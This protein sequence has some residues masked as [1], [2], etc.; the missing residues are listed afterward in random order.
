MRARATSASPNTS[1]KITSTL[2]W[3]FDSKA[4][5]ENEPYIEA[6]LQR[7]TTPLVKMMAGQ[8]TRTFRNFHHPQ[9]AEDDYAGPRALLGNRYKLVVQNKRGGEPKIELFDVRDDPAE[10]KN[11]AGDQPDRV[12][13]MQTEFEA[14]IAAGRSTPGASQAND[15]KVRRYPR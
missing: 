8:Y 10:T 13:Q 2:R 4:E 1:H 9:I 15:V 14:L 11:L 12:A 6:E 7:G 5:S 3:S